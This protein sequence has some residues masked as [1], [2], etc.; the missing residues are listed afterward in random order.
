MTFI[1]LFDKNNALIML[2]DKNNA[3]Y[4]FFVYLLEVYL[5]V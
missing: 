1:M 5:Q 3:Q 2:F 4:L